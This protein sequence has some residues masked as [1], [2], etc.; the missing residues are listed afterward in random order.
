MTNLMAFAQSMR[1][2]S[3]Y[4]PVEYSVAFDWNETK[5]TWSFMSFKIDSTYEKELAAAAQADG[6]H[7]YRRNGFFVN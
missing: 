1:T 7:I 6:G 2:K 5:R 3:H 4:Y